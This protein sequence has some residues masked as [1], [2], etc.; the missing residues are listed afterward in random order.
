VLEIAIPIV[1]VVLVGILVVYGL[2]FLKRRKAER[3]RMLEAYWES[4][5]LKKRGNILGRRAERS[6][7]GDAETIVNT[8]VVPVRP[9][10]EKVV[11][12]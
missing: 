6:S 7:F 12:K 3:K 9:V 4:E 2:R 10:Q 8:N 5:E 1:C 11:V